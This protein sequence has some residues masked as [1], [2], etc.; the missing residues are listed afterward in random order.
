MLGPQAC[1]LP[2]GGSGGATNNAS[3]APP[4]PPSNPL[5]DRDVDKME[6]RR[7]TKTSDTNAT[8]KVGN[9]TFGPGT[10]ILVIGDSHI[11]DERGRGKSDFPFGRQLIKDIK[12][13][14]SELDVVAQ[15]G[16]RPAT[17]LKDAKLKAKLDKAIEN[18]KKP[19]LDG[20][21]P[22]G[23]VIFENGTN[24]MGDISE[25]GLPSAKTHLAY[26]NKALKDLPEGTNIVFVGRPWEKSDGKDGKPL[27]KFDATMQ[28]AID[29]YNADPKSK[30]H[31]TYVSS[32]DATAGAD[33]SAPPAGIY[34]GEHIKDEAAGQ[35]WANKVFTAI[36][37]SEP[38]A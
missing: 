9:G 25:M 16:A 24:F 23:T 14:G 33:G 19:G 34:S 11:A 21:T 35:R 20:T 3:P 15:S 37:G 12:G 1:Q 17:Y 22:K 13:T 18:F 6:P 29:E 27:D 31:I 26:M 7:T 38:P 36:G 32:K 5:A 8:N 10:R 4:P 2:A 28:K 30:F